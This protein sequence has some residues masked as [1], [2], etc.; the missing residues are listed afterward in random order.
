M[1]G[2]ASNLAIFITIFFVTCQNPNTGVTNQPQE[3][4]ARPTF[5]TMQGTP[6]LDGSGSDDIWERTEWQP[7]SH[8]W[9]GAQPTPDDFTGRYKLAWD[10]NNLYI[11]AETTDDSLLDAL[12]TLERFWDDD[13]LVV[14]LDEDASGGE[15][16]FSYNAFAYHI[17]LDGQVADMAPDSSFRFFDGHCLSRR[18]S[19]DN[20]STWE[21]AVRVYDG[22]QYTDGGDNVPKLL[23]KGKKMGFALAYCDNDRSPERESFMGNVAIPEAQKSRGRLNA[24]AFG[25]LELR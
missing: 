23:K 3:T 6:A 13:C 14:L 16:E 17:A 1:S 22:K 24:D 8:L 10:E 25:I 5:V 21:I 15:Y 18:I 11:L 12:Q 4:G 7:I 20:T 2:Y 9:A 19:R